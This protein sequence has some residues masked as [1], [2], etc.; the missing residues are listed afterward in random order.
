MHKTT[1]LVSKVLC[2]IYITYQRHESIHVF[3]IYAV[4]SCVAA[5]KMQHMLRY[6]SQVNE[7]DI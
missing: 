4:Y 6:E 2:L 1:V 5:S 7:K 3:A